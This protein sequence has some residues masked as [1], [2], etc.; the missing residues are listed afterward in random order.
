[1]CAY[2]LPVSVAHHNRESVDYIVD[3]ITSISFVQSP[4]LLVIPL[5]NSCC[6]NLEAA[7]ENELKTHA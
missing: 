3:T 2:S 5:S 4:Y 6:S 7:H 1:M